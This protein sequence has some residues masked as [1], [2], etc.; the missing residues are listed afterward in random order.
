MRLIFCGTPRFAVPT[1]AALVERR[2]P[3]DLVVT[4]PDEPSGRSYE[5]KAPPVKV[6]AERSGLAVFQPA[7][8][9]D[10][11]TQAFISAYRP[12]AIVVVAYGHI[13]PPWMVELPRLG[14][15]NLHASLLP[16]YRGAAPVAWAL[17]RGERVT[18][19]TTMK[20]DAGLDTG[21]ILLQR[22]VGIEDADTTATL[23]ERMSGIGAGLMVET[24]D[25]LERG[26]IQPRPQDHAA[27]TLAPML[28]KEDG[29]IDWS[30]RVEEIARRV[31]GLDP[32]P[33]AYTTFRGK[34]LRLWSAAATPSSPEA[35]AGPGVAWV[36]GGRLI[37]ACG[38]GTGLELRE[39][40]LEG[41]KRIPA[42]DFLNGVRLAPGE[43]LGG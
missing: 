31:R 36:E 16:K 22:E 34:N 7:K 28:K 5:V 14:C 19:L 23:L 11:A 6:E 40:Q 30:L 26:M 42:R 25:G 20:I 17:I 1:L 33:G 3:I 18:G 4:N 24:L 38:Q 35:T 9:K 32:W 15:I 21:D 10:P 43:K 8:L 39:L 27:A 29:R 2:I 12:D 13:I 37:V 41:R